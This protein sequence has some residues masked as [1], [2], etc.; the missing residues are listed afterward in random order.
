MNR[1]FD[2]D[3]PWD[4]AGGGGGCGLILFIALVV[5]LGYFSLR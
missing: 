2:F 3:N 5:A 4:G 1:H